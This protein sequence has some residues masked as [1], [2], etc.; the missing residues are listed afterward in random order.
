M[1]RF[2]FSRSSS[3]EVD[4]KV[5]HPILAQIRARLSAL[6]PVPHRSGDARA[7]AV[8]LV[9]RVAGS[10][11]DV[12]F[13]KRAEYELD[14][15]S[16]Q[17]AFPGGRHEPG[18]ND[19]VETAVR[20][21][22]EELGID[23]RSNAEVI[24]RLDDLHSTTVKLPNVYV[25]PFVLAVS[26][27]PEMTLS[28]EVAESFWVPLNV[29]RANASWRMT[30]VNARGLTFEVRACQFEGKVIWGMTERIISQ[31]LEISF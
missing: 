17:V 29:L 4:K 22:R 18:D 11:L 3:A 26:Q 7:A 30:S 14:P 8:A 20:E 12:L 13:I 31:L 16:G 15:W 5:D 27:L 19:L 6:S 23:L 9:L 2:S 1:R 28:P 24:G 10:D 25:R 21:T